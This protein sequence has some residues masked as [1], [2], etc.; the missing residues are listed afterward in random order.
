MDLDA[1]VV[2]VGAG[3]AGLTTAYS[4]LQKNP[5]LIVTVLEATDKIGGRVLSTPLLVQNKTFRSFDLGGQWISSQQTPLLDLLQEL[6]IQTE[7]R[8]DVGKIVVNA[9]G[10]LYRRNR[11]NPWGFCSSAAKLEMAAFAAKIEK[12]C[13]RKSLEKEVASR[14]MQDFI[15]EHLSHDINKIIVRSLILMHC[16]VDARN[17]TVG[18]YIFFCTSTHGIA[19]QLDLDGLHELRI[20]NG[21]QD[22]CNKI[23]TLLRDTITLH[24]NTKVLQIKTNK[25]NVEIDSSRGTFRSRNVVVAVAPPA[26]S[27]INFLPHLPAPKIRALRSVVCGTLWKFVVS[28]QYPFW[29]KEGFSGDIY[30]LDGEGPPK[31]P[32]ICCFNNIVQN[33]AALSG[34]FTPNRIQEQ[35]GF[36]QELAQ[37]LGAP[38]LQPLQLAARKWTASPMCCFNSHEDVEHISSSMKRVF[39]AGAETSMEW[40]G[41]ICG[42]V[43]SGYRAATEVLYDMHPALLTVSDLGTLTPNSTLIRKRMRFYDNIYRKMLNPHYQVSTLFG[44]VLLLLVW[45]KFNINTRLR[46]ILLK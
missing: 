30:I 9:E 19:N 27:T 39:W 45:R 20:R 16:G 40:Y 10:R 5:S 29:W 33:N 37:Y 7:Q 6:E 31:C 13:L 41:T 35:M 11:R 22:I 38:T 8:S 21:A 32:I 17:L 2:V 42:A 36:L 15:E 18:F 4:L 43:I 23:A 12:L 28:Y 46:N 24:V 44:V 3:V 14:K 34:Y 1:D 25:Y 26:I